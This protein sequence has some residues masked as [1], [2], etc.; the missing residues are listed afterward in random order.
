MFPEL[1]LLDNCGGLTQRLVNVAERCVAICGECLTI[2][3]DHGVCRQGTGRISDGHQFFSRGPYMHTG[4]NATLIRCKMTETWQRCSHSILGE[5]F[6]A[7]WYYSALAPQD[8]IEQSRCALSD[9]PVGIGSNAKQVIHSE[10]DLAI[11]TCA[12]DR[13]ASK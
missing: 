8:V 1:S 12:N 4:I 5:A 2:N 11:N 3:K 10:H 6:E 9:H 7:I 13:R